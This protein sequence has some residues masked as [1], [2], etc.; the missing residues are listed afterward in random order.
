MTDGCQAGQLAG[1]LV[2]GKKVHAV[3]FFY[4]IIWLFLWV[5]LLLTNKCGSCFIR[6]MAPQHHSTLLPNPNPHPPPPCSHLLPPPKPP[7]P[8]PQK[9]LLRPSFAGLFL[10]FSV[11]SEYFAHLDHTGR[12]TDCYQ[13]AELCLGTYEFVATKDYCKVNG[14]TVFCFFTFGQWRWE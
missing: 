11:P 8:P 3:I 9:K 2:F 12:R 4:C 5:F 14:G 1:C 7:N 13:R 6:M 10:E